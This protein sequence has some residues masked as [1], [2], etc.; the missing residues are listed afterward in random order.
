MTIAAILFDLDNTLYPV[1]SGLMQGV[2]TRI[3]QYVQNLLGLGWEQALELRRRYFVDYGT[4]LRGLQHNHTVDPED[5]LAYVHDLVLE[6]FLAS[7]AE[8]DR[9]LGQVAATKV[10]FTNSPI[11]YARRVLATLGID[12]H[13]AQIFDIRFFAF[14]PKPDPLAYQRALDALGLAGAQT[15]LVEDTAQNLAPARAL[16]MRTIL[17]AAQP[18][19]RLAVSADHV[20]PDIL[21]ALRIVLEL[22]RARP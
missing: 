14:L 17:V 2:D 10:V 12:R 13:F 20:A 5:Y 18:D 9:L 8:L 6:S 3:T 11:E 16:G 19:T 4:T 21:A 22:E 15:L 7:D 1:S